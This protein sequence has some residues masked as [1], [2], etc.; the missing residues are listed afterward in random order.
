MSQRLRD[1]RVAWCKRQGFDNAMTGRVFL[2]WKGRRL[3]DVTTCKSLDIGSSTG[4][5]WPADDHDS[6]LQIHVEAVTEELLA[7]R[8]KRTEDESGTE[9]S[10]ETDNFIRITLKCPDL[11]EFKIKVKPSTRISR[12]ISTFRSARNVPLDKHVHLLFDGETLSPDSSVEEHDVA[13]LD[14]IDISIK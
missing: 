11:D 4:S 2:T 7:S 5:D 9:D 3:F 6:G 13:D 12:I 8:D 1:V 14:L 10:N